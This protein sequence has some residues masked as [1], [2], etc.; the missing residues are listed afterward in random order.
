[1][2]L[3]TLNIW[4]AKIHKP[5]VEFL[6]RESADTDIFCFQEVYNGGS[7]I[8]TGGDVTNIYSELEGLLPDFVAL[9]SESLSCEI[10]GIQVP[11]GI[12]LFVRKNVT[13][14]KQGTFEIFASHDGPR[15]SLKQGIRLWNRL[16]QFVTISLNGK[17]V[18][19]FNLHGLW[20]GGGK[21]DNEGRIEQSTR[22]RSIMDSFEGEKILCGDFNLNPETESMKILE[23]GMRNL[24]TENGITSTR[25]HYYIKEPKFAD[26]S[27]VTPG[28]NVSGFQVLQDV[29]S[30]HLAL[31]LKFEL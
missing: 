9:Y 24:I 28:V 21:D 4:G 26:Y 17:Q 7:L 27:L 6:K 12:A 30:D 25:S 13:V 8:H 1:M 15:L 11:Y 22:V 18:T 29:V 20:I 16:L 2:K 5:L 23:Q 14:L 19:I 31:Q 3:I 10:H